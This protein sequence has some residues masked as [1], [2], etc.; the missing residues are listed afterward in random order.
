MMQG[1]VD[2]ISGVKIWYSSDEPPTR[3]TCP[4]DKQ[5]FWLADAIDHC[6]D[7]HPDC[8]SCGAVKLLLRGMLA[9]LKHTAIRS[10]HQ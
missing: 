1:S 10:R 2:T 5:Q 6:G 8:L 9:V 7:E 4:H 3:W